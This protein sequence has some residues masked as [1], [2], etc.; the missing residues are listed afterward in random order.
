MMRITTEIHS[1]TEAEYYSE[2]EAVSL[3]FQAE[4]GQLQQSFTN[5]QGFL[6]TKSSAATEQLGSSNAD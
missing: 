1:I 5:L 2:R 4:I 3:G 6:R